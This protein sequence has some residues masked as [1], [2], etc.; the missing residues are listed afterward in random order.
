ML[1]QSPDEGTSCVNSLVAVRTRSHLLLLIDY[2]YL[3][4]GDSFEN[5]L[6]NVGGAVPA[7]TPEGLISEQ[8]RR[9]E[10]ASHIF[11]GRGV[12]EWHEKLL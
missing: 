12:A 1:T 3:L 7:A 5:G 6:P 10:R 8:D 11:I 9:A 2:H 4:F